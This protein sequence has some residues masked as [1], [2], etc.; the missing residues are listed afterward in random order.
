MDRRSARGRWK[1]GR[2]RLQA[3]SR[4][5]GRADRQYYAEWVVLR[6]LPIDSFTKH[7]AVRFDFG[8]PNNSSTK[9]SPGR[10]EICLTRRRIGLIN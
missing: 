10:L 8:V 1:L 3:A 4:D 2:V 9:R 7:S 5:W 6:G